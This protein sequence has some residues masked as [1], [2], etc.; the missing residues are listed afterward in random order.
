MATPT[1]SSAPLRDLPTSTYSSEAEGKP[2]GCIVP[3]TARIQRRVS[4]YG[5][6]TVSDLCE[7]GAALR[8]ELRRPHGGTRLAVPLPQ[9]HPV[10][11]S[12]GP[13]HI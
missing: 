13:V 9:A 5:A 7:I 3:Y 11:R 12:V 10:L 8:T 1:P 2:I 6:P 4:L